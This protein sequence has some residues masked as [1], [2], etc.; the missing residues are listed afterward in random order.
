MYVDNLGKWDYV[1]NNYPPSYPD[2]EEVEIISLEVLDTAWREA[3]DVYY[4]K[5]LLTYLWENAQRFR[6]RNVAHEPNLH[7]ER[8]TLDFQADY[9][10]LRSLFEA[11]Y[12]VNPLFGMEDIIEYLDAHPELRRINAMHRD[13]Y[14]WLRR[15]SKEG[16]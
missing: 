5:Y 13:Y 1:T 11:L 3:T 16:F 4:R 10:L 9:E 12:P 6:I 8:W 2:G 15:E 14:P 7:Q